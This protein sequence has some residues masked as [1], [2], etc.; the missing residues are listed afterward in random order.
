MPAKPHLDKH[1]TEPIDLTKDFSDVCVDKFI[2]NVCGVRWFYDDCIAKTMEGLDDTI[3]SNMKSMGLI[4]SSSLLY[5]VF[6]KDSCDGMGDVSVYKG[7]GDRVLW[8][9]TSQTSFCILKMQVTIDDTEHTVF[10][11]EYLNSV[12]TNRLLVEAVTKTTLLLH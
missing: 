11:E 1:S 12:G 9:K 2:P 5:K 8:D 7:T 3:E 10:E 4:H 6:I